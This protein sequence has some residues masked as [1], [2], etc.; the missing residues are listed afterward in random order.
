MGRPVYSIIVL[1]EARSNCPVIVPE[2][3]RQQ[4]GRGLKS[5]KITILLGAIYVLYDAI[6]N[7]FLE[8]R[9]TH[10]LYIA[11]CMNAIYFNIRDEQSLLV[12]KK[13]T[14]PLAILS[15]K[16]ISFE[17][18]TWINLSKHSNRRCERNAADWVRFLIKNLFLFTHI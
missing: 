7:S 3:G 9:L 17:I 8:A 14:N 1:I 2:P 15:L 5:C 10:R 6:I 13:I 16:E 18:S 4:S 11:S 12:Y